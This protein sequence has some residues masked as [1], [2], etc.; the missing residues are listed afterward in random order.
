LGCGCRLIERCLGWL[1]PA[2]PHRRMMT[3]RSSTL[4]VAKGIAFLGAYGV[5]V[6]SRGRRVRPMGAGYSAT[7]LIWGDASPVLYGMIGVRGVGTE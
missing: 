2:G 5:L 3:G 1:Y 7:A 4:L 6:R